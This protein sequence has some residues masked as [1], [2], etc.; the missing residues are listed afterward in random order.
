MKKLLF[1]FGTRPEA[2]KMAPVILEAKSQG[3]DVDVCLTGQHRE[4]IAPFLDF[5]QINENYTLNVMR[6]NQSLN[7]LTSAI[8]SEMDK[9]L[10][11]S[12]PDI[13]EKRPVPSTLSPR[14]A[15]RDAQ[16]DAITLA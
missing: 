1:C 10:A 15:E 16:V 14:R 12:N 7:T 9:V 8:L 11:D 13:L 3:F 2:I 5:F 4:M 6:E